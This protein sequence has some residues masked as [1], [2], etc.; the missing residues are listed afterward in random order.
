MELGHKVSSHSPHM[1][2]VAAPSPAG[3]GTA[4]APLPHS[5][6]RNLIR[7]VSPPAPDPAAL[8]AKVRE[9]SEINTPNGDGE[10]PLHRAAN[11]GDAA[12]MLDLI[13][14]GANVN[15]K[16]VRGQTPLHAMFEHKTSLAVVKALL[17]AGADVNARSVSDR[18][19][20]H[21]AYW[22]NPELIPV[23]VAAGA[24][25]NARD[26]KGNTALMEAAGGDGYRMNAPG[27]KALL[28]AGAD[29][30]VRNKC[31]TSA[32]DYAI[33]S[34]DQDIQ[35]LLRAAGAPSSAEELNGRCERNQSFL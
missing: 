33:A 5:G 31:G 27:V 25:V 10:T 18:T 35:A 29:L 11:E 34:E 19:P 9:A 3:P 13:A 7:A 14:R 16:D 17:A 22:R 30:E 8:T 28:A 12:A 32:L 26:R 20:L 6:D 15:V 4:A 24:D 21:E 23:L 1:A 2:P